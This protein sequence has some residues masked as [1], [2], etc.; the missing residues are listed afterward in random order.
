M[1]HHFAVL[2]TTMLVILTSRIGLTQ[3]KDWKGET[4]NLNFYFQSSLHEQTAGWHA[5]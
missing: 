1:E 3:A 4:G 5:N 2:T